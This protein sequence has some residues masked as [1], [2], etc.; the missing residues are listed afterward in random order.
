MEPFL[1]ASYNPSAGWSAGR[2]SQPESPREREM[3]QIHFTKEGKVVEC[4]R[5]E[6]LRD[7]ARRHGIELYPGLKRILNCRGLGHCG[8]C[9]VHVTG[10]AENLS[11]KGLREKFRIAVS[12]FKLGNEDRVRLACQ[13]RVEGDVTIETQPDFNWFGQRK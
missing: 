3:P 12:W 8:E 11:K 5:G 9:R 13:A 7:V 1:L 10:G 4:E 6:K 2:A